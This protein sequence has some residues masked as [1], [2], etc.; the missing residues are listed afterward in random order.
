M[1]WFLVI[2]ALVLVGPTY[3]LAPLRVWRTSR[4]PLPRARPVSAEE[5]PV[6]VRAAVES[7]AQT[8]GT[9]GFRLRGV[10]S[11]NDA[12]GF[13]I[14]AYHP[15]HGIHFL[16]YHV[17]AFRWQVFLTRFRDGHEVV[18][19]NPP[20][21]SVF[22]RSPQVHGCSFPP[23]TDVGT[24]HEAHLAHLR[25]RGAG[26]PLAP[27]TAE[28]AAFITGV[29]ERTLEGQRTCGIMTREADVF[30]PTLGGAFIQTWRMLPPLKGLRAAADARTVEEV[31]QGVAQSAG[32]RTA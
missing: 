22:S 16:D 7:V 29:E 2:A 28:S 1:L 13:V 21:P 31:R 11:V 17:G 20:I 14:H 26:R 25:L 6:A 24:L 5:A 27:S 4:T 8:L 30:R 3:L 32:E 12:T 18:T 10:C 23:G 9:S 15:D 19:S